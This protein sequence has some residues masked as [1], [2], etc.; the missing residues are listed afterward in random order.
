MAARFVKAGEIAEKFSVSRD[1]VYLW[2][3][4]GRIPSECVIR[5]AG[6]VRVDWEEFEKY[7]HSGDL[8]TRLV[9]RQ[10]NSGLI[11]SDNST[12]IPTKPIGDH[13]WRFDPK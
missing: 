11:D 4:E 12:M 13:P 2:I 7:L 8:Y 10:H 3:R 9:D 5:I 1:A 6:T